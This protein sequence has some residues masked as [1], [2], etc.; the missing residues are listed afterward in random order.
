MM[1]RRVRWNA[2]AVPAAI[3][4][5]ACSSATSGPARGATLPVA[6]PADQARPAAGA[7]ATRTQQS[8]TAAD[9]H[10]MSSMI[11]HHAQAIVM[12]GMAPTH[13]AGP[14]IRTL[15]ERIINAQQDEIAIMQ[16]WLRDRGQPVPDLLPR[17]MHAVSGGGHA[18]GHAMPGM[19]TGAQLN[20]LDQAR[21]KEFDR[22]FLSFMIQ[23]HQ[24]AV[25]MVR[26]LIGSTGA[27]H[28]DTVFKLASDINVDQTTEIDRMQQMLV[29]LLSES[30]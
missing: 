22:L 15:A 14:S 24:G 1:R 8:Y 13:D 21:G 27:A 2:P 28:D 30:R 7:P 6:G 20:Q 16:Q 18:H 17:G 29:A 4:L 10:F 25:S 11:G 12:A 26:E 9:V 3:L 19:L 23:H 5:A